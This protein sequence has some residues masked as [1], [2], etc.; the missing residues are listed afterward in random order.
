V[1]NLRIQL[2][3]ET[4]AK[5]LKRAMREGT[6]LTEVVSN[7]LRRYINSPKM[8]ATGALNPQAPVAALTVNGA[9]SASPQ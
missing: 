7:E 6:T 9:L 8:E 3:D 5:A 1:T 4:L 2:D